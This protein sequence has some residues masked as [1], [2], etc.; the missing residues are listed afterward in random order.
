VT[1]PAPRRPKTC[2]KKCFRTL[3]AAEDALLNA[4]I[5]QALRRTTRRREVRAYVCRE[6]RAWHL[7]SQPNPFEKGQAS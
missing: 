6:C 3:A 2:R 1:G 4:R 7:T 5:Q